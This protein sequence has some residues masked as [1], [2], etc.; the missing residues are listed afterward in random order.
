MGDRRF[1]T[2]AFI[3]VAAESKAEAWEKVVQ[4]LEHAGVSAFIVKTGDTWVR[5][6]RS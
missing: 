2:Q 4:I 6:V 3:T 1:E 5:E